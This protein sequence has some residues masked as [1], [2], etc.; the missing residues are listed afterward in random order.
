MSMPAIGL[1]PLPNNAAQYRPKSRI[2]GLFICFAEKDA[3]LS[4]SAGISV[5]VPDTEVGNEKK[6]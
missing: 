6:Q 4:G 3:A 1:V 5:V 2:S